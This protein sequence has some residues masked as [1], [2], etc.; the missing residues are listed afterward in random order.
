MPTLPFKQ[1]DVFTQVRF[2]G[3]P[4]AVVMDGQSLSTSQMQQIANWTN[5]SETTFLLPPSE[6]GADYRVRIFTPGAELPF[7]GH[8][9]I[10]TAH[11]LM[12]SGAIRPRAGRLV[13]QCNAGLIPLHVDGE[14]PDRAIAFELPEA[15]FSTLEAG[16][17]AELE[18]LLGASPTGAE[19]L[20]VDVGPRWVVL[21]LGS[22]QDVLALAP[23]M[24]R[25]KAQDLRLR[26]TGVVVFGEHPPGGPSRVEVRAFAP[27]HGI[28]EDPVCG[29]GNGAL[30]AF[31]RHTGQVG[32]FGAD[33]V[34]SQ[35]AAVGRAGLV[36]LMIGTDGIRVGGNA[37]TCIDGMIAV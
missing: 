18:G 24:Q 35:G 29:S 13:Q 25:M 7:A 2:K 20:V 30:A 12:E 34:A 16:D 21:Q 32:R 8:P 14:G 4:V 11:A 9:T 6:A 3:N 37:V 15:K 31:V 1:V 27:A 17:R 5:L 33:L 10:G 19:P 36:R 28:P 22:A 23:D 26:L